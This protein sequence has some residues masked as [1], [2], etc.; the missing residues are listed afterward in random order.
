M[1]SLR[2]VIDML[3]DYPDTTIIFGENAFQQFEVL[4]YDLKPQKLMLVTGGNSIRRHSGLQ[5]FYQAFDYLG[6]MIHDYSGVEPEPGTDTVMKMIAEFEAFQPDAVVAMGGGSVMDAA[7]AAWLIYQS[8]NSLQE[9]FGVNRWSQAHPGETLKRLICFPTTSG[10]GSEV[11]PYSN[12]VDHVAG[13]KKLIVETAAIPEYAFVCPEL[14][15]TMP[16]KVIRATACDALAHLIE[17]FINIGQDGNHPGVNEW[18]LAGI[19]L[20]VENLPERLAFPKR[21]APAEALA[22]AATLG[23]MVIR[24]KSTGLPHLCSFSWFGQVEHGIAVAMLLPAAWRYYLASSEVAARTMELRE[25]FP[26]DNPAEIIV[27]YRD[28]LTRCGVPRALKDIPD[29]PVSL[30]EKTAASAAENRMKL[31]LAPHPV[32]L[33]QSHEIL[34]RLLQETWSDGC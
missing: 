5:H 13:V 9:H 28:F 11:T 10:T 16:E 15:L 24:Y 4:M 7:K 33:E 17:G 34:M 12:I 6:T 3:D 21:R 22:L 20:I 32:P 2:N 29:F 23:G 1:N 26:G 19:R 25:I 18:A 14:T 27:A 31:E 30:L 8:R